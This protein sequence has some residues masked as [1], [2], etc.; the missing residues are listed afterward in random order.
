[1]QRQHREQ[2]ALLRAAQLDGA[3]VEADLDQ[4]EEM[5]VHCPSQQTLSRAQARLNRCFTAFNRCSAGLGQLP[6]RSHSPKP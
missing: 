3:P 5:Y 4:A 2:G 6:E 1:M